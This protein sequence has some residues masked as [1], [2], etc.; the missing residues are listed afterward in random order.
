[1]VGETID[2]KVETAEIGDASIKANLA[3]FTNRQYKRDLGEGETLKDHCY[4]DIT[5]GRIT[6]D[7]QK[8]AGNSNYYRLVLIKKADGTIAIYDNSDGMYENGIN[9][10][11]KEIP[12]EDS[13]TFPKGIKSK[14]LCAIMAYNAEQRKKSSERK[15]KRLAAQKNNNPKAP[16]QERKSLTQMIFK[17][18]RGE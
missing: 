14:L 13:K 5:T 7:E 10:H 12:F 11:L 1:M 4:M 6:F 3:A 17:L 9:K 2:S 18:I 8:C 16:P 15:T